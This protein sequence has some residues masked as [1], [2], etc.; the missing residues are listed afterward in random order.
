MEIKHAWCVPFFHRMRSFHVV[1]PG[2]PGRHRRLDISRRSGLR[3][4]QRSAGPLVQ[5]KRK[6]AV[7]GETCPAFAAKP[8]PGCVGGRP[9]TGR[10]W[11]EDR[12]RRPN[13]GIRRRLARLGRGN[14]RT[15]RRSARTAGETSR[16][17]PGGRSGNSP[18]GVLSRGCYPAKSIVSA[19]VV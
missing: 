6:A 4:P 3:A 14:C 7:D 12:R 18:P 9:P 8:Q 11:R 5:Q 2:R 13:M 15:R 17:Q 10:T 19:A 16:A 1:G